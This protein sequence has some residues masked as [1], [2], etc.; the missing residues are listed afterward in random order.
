MP[1]IRRGDLYRVRH[2]SGDPKRSRVFVVVARQAALE[3]KFSTAV[4]APVL[5]QGDGLTTQVPVGPAEGLK[6]ES[7]ILCDGL[8]SIEKTRLT[9]FVGSLPRHKLPVLALALRSALGLG[10]P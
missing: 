8:T 3:S 1:A 6:H 5:S 9:D 2:P 10:E 7:W 4:C